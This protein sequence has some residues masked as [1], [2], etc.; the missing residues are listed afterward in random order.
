MFQQ[1]TH[2]VD[3]GVSYSKPWIWAWGQ[4]LLVIQHGNHD[5]GYEDDYRKGKKKME[6]TDMGGLQVNTTTSSKFTFSVSFKGK[7]QKA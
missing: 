4:S 1:V 3:I 2:K 5:L 7:Q 6:E